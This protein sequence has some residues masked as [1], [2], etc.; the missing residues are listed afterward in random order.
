MLFIT[1]LHSLND[2]AIAGFAMEINSDIDLFRRLE[3]ES[4][5][6]TFTSSTLEKL[7]GLWLWSDAV[8]QSHVEFKH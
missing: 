6:K 3:L 1:S 8:L 7:K 4:L 2:I 5:Y